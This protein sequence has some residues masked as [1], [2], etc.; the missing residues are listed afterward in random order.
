MIVWAPQQL[1][2]KKWTGQ[3]FRYAHAKL[4]GWRVTAYRQADGTVKVFGKD[5]RIHLE[6]LS[7]FP[8]LK[9]TNWYKTIKRE[10]RHTAFDAEIIVPGRP[11]SFVATALRDKTV[12]IEIVTFAVPWLDGKRFDAPLPDVE[13]YVEDLGLDFA[14]WWH[15]DDKAFHDGDRNTMLAFARKMGMEGF[16]LKQR[17]YEGWFKLKIERTVDAVVTGFEWGEGKY[18]GMVGALIVSVLDEDTGHWIEIANCSG[19][20]DA[21]R[22][23]MTCLVKKR[24]LCDRACELMYQEVSSK[25]RLRHPRFIRWREDKL[26]EECTIEQLED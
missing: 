4:D 14:K 13:E 11:A 17:H 7:R 9:R 12:P 5:H 2:P 22:K 23:E 21:E 1:K 3:P 18:K 25:G 19:M 24:K 20:T 10:P 8:R 16:V 6:Y 15:V 26:V